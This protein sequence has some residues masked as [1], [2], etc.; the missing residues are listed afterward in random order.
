M[1]KKNTITTEQF[2]KLDAFLD[3][4]PTANYTI[5]TTVM[6]LAPKLIQKI[7]EDG[8]TYES[9]AE[10]IQTALQI[11]IAPSALRL[12]LNKYRKTLNQSEVSSKE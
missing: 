2:K 6:N 3:K 12:Y 1:A 4:L 5:E 11:T 9:L 8:Y 7:D 10:V